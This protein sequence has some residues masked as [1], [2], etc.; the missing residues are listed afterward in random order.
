MCPRS[1]SWKCPSSVVMSDDSCS[2]DPSC[3]LSPKGGGMA[4]VLSLELEI[5]VLFRIVLG[6]GQFPSIFLISSDDSWLWERL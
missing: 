6:K 1:L 4:S 2:L 3:P 5:P